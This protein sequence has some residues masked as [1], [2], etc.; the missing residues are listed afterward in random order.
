MM[1]QP[2]EHLG[3][4]G[5]SD[6]PIMSSYSDYGFSGSITKPYQVVELS[7]VLDKIVKGN[8]PAV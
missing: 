3:T 2:W 6:D 5:Y 1:R 8:Q 4:S 7:K